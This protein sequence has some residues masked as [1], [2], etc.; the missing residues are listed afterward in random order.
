MDGRATFPVRGSFRR[1]MILGMGSF[2]CNA[3]SN[4]S[5]TT[6]RGSVKKMMSVAYSATGLFTVTFSPTLRFPDAIDVLVGNSCADMTAT[7]FFEANLKGDPSATNGSFVVACTQVLPD[8][9]YGSI[10]YTFQKTNTDT[11]G[12][13]YTFNGIVLQNALLVS[14]VTFTPDATVTHNGTNYKTLNLL[15]NNAAGGGN[16]TVALVNSSTADWTGGQPVTLAI[17]S[18]PVTI[19]AGSQL[20]IS[21]I[22]TA[23]GYA[24]GTGTLTLNGTNA[25]TT[26]QAFAPPNTAGNRIFFQF[27]GHNG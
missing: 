20:A 1:D 9:Q 11:A 3:A 19:P 24:L 7:N 23:S 12:T 2:Q 22:H 21:S 25:I 8:A 6:F 27:A 18:G 17:Q 10:Q 5:S 16:T 14:S 26:P 13:D 15:Y 4:P